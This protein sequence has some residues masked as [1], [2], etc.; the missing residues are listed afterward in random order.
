[1]AMGRRREARRS[2]GEQRARAR[3]MIGQ[4]RCLAWPALRKCVL[5]FMSDASRLEEICEA[6]RQQ[7]DC[8]IL[9]FIDYAMAAAVEGDRHIDLIIVDPDCAELG[10]GDRLLH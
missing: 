4:R 7:H 6:L 3:A 8:E 9:A 1:M 10:Q 5:I 2:A